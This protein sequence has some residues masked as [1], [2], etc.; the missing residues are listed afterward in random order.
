MDDI[1]PVLETPI[2]FGAQ[3]LANEANL[4]PGT[5]KAFNSLRCML[6]SGVAGQW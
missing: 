6:N 3:Y 5:V 4:G 2:V 1:I